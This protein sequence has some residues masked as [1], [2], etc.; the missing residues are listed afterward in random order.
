MSYRYE[1]KPEGYQPDA[2]Y[3]SANVAAV[4]AQGRYDSADDVF[5]NEEGAQV[6]DILF[7]ALGT[8]NLT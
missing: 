1:T 8:G 2:D 5:G 7:Q 6:G 3:E 4:T